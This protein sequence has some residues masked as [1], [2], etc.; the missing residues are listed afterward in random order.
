MRHWWPRANGCV[1]IPRKA[2]EKIRP[3]QSFS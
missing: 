2:A 3:S 1:P